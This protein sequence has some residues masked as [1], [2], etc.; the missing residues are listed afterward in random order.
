MKKIFIL[1]VVFYITTLLSSCA[2]CLNPD[3]QCKW[4]KE[5]DWNKG[6]EKNKIKADEGSALEQRHFAIRL[7]MKT[8]S[9]SEDYINKTHSIK[10]G[11]DFL[12]KSANKGDALAQYL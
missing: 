3:G 5:R 9:E 4:E 10:E 2:I 8:D 1:S 12:E 7:L 11:I 6:F